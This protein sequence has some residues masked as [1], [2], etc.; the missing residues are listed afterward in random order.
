MA[1]EPKLPPVPIRSGFVVAL[2]VVVSLCIV[3]FGIAMLVETG[4]DVHIET[5]TRI[6]L[7]VAILVAPVVAVVVGRGRR[8]D[9]RVCLLVAAWISAGACL[10]GLFV[11][12]VTTG[13]VQAALAG[14]IVGTAINLARSI[15][16][17]TVPGA[18]PSAAI[19][20]PRRP[21]AR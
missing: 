5:V 4:P 17:R 16:P 3:P 15:K 1:V 10:A 2:G 12:T 13:I 19:P 11:A 8:V 18:D 7:F 9:V 14:A 20:T 6:A 21:D